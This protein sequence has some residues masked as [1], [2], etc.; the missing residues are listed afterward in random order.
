MT[1]AGDN[2]CGDQKGEVDDGETLHRHF[3][4]YTL[5]TLLFIYASG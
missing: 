2:L 3:T 4:G 1:A 5:G